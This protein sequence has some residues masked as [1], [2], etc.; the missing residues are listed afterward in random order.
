MKNVNNELLSVLKD[1]RTFVNEAMTS[2]NYDTTKFCAVTGI[3]NYVD[4]NASAQASD[5]ADQLMRKW[6]FALVGD[7][8]YI[9][10]ASRDKLQDADAASEIY[11]AASEEEMWFEGE[12][13]E[14]RRELLD[15]MIEQLEESVNG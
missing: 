7:G 11:Q 14:L 12:Y 8:G 10:P 13:A 2:G 5:L 9:V 4:I 6:E 1:L 15:W 3:C